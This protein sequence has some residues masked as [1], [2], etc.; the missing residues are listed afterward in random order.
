[1]YKSNEFIGIDVSKDTF[2]VWGPSFGHLCLDNNR[3]GFREL[4]KQLK[5]N[6][7]CVMEAIGSYHQQLA[8]YY[9]MGR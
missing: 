6:A 2:D 4:K 3:K 8:Q 7:W 1:M 9:M 5:E